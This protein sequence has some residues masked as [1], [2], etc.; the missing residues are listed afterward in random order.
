MISL[1]D[2]GDTTKTR[3]WCASC[4]DTASPDLMAKMPCPVLRLL[5]LPYANQD[6]YRAEWRP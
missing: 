2:P 4:L 5:A 1:H 6:G 3:R